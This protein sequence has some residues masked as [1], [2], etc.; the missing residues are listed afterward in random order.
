MKKIKKMKNKLSLE[1]DKNT[2]FAHI[3]NN[4]EQ[5][6]QELSNKKFIQKITLEFC[7]GERAKE[8]RLEYCA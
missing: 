6:I 3:Q 4:S 5:R 7:I 1:S 2:R 8:K